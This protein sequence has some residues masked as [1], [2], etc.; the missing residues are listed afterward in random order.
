M[1][2]L[3]LLGDGMVMKELYSVVSN[4][5]GK[6]QFSPEENWMSYK[7]PSEHKNVHD[8]DMTSVYAYA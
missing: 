2:G 1:E 4:I 5:L 6:L 7:I 8:I 3:Y